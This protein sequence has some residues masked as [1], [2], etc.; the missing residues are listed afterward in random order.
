MRRS[1]SPIIII[2]ALLFATGITIASAQQKKTPDAPPPPDPFQKAKTVFIK[3]QGGSVIPFNVISSNMEG[4]DRF[5]LVDVTGKAD[6]ILEV[7]SPREITDM[8]V[9]SPIRD[10]PQ[11]RRSPDQPTP[12][13][14]NN[15]AEP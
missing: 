11:S 5:T 15:F 8:A 1:S 6:I 2:L 12:T 7:I 4:W 13:P 14:Q 9:A 3:Q 10:S